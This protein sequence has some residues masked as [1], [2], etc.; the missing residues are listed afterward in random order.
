MHTCDRLIYKCDYTCT[1]CYRRTI[2]NIVTT[3][4]WLPIYTEHSFA[5]VPL[6][7]CLLQLVCCDCGHHVHSLQ[8]SHS[9]PARS[10]HHTR[11]TCIRFPFC[12]QRGISTLWD[13]TSFESIVAPCSV[14]HERTRGLQRDSCPGTYWHNKSSS[15]TS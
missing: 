14:R 10:K 8:A 13:S 12:P 6:F 2:Y 7:I 1:W 9:I 15:C 5:H 4:D 3:L 11:Q